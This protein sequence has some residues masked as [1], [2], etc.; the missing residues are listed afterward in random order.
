[1][2]SGPLDD[3]IT[4]QLKTMPEPQSRSGEPEETWADLFDIWADYQPVNAKEFPAYEK[5]YSETTARF[6][7]RYPLPQHI[8]LDPD[9]HR[10]VMVFDENSS[11]ITTQTFNILGSFPIDGDRFGLEIQ[12]SEI[13]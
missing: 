12:V 9:K 10:I 1:M 2:K 3:R 4:I 11:P 5:R 6:M 13:V 7:V 8:R